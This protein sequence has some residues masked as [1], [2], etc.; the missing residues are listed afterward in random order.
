[1][2]SHVTPPPKKKEALLYFLPIVA[3]AIKTIFPMNR[4]LQAAPQYWHSTFRAMLNSVSYKQVK[5][6]P[7]GS[8]SYYCNFY[9]CRPIR[10]HIDREVKKYGQINQE[11]KRD[12]SSRHNKRFPFIHWL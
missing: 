2:T 1:M 12:F 3:S 4:P 11:I 10:P 8:Q 9:A 6:A 5:A 7:A